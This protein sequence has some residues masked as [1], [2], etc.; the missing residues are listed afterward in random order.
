VVATGL[1]GPSGEP[2]REIL[3]M[4]A[5]PAQGTARFP[6]RLRLHRET[7]PGE[8]E[9]VMRLEN[10][11]ESRVL[12]RVDEQAALRVRP[13]TLE[14]AGHPGEWVVRTVTVENVGNV[15][16][17]LGKLGS[18]ILDEDAAF[19]RA[20]QLALRRRGDEGARQVADAFAAEFAGSRVDLLRARLVERALRIDVGEAVRTDIEFHLPVQLKPG[21]TYV[22]RLDAQQLRIGITVRAGGRGAASVIEATRE[23]PRQEGQP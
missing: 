17:E 22:G 15:P 2:I 23:T 7:P 11:Q 10:G 5:V 13:T 6:V 19:C 1:L 20:M 14:L 8:H 16:A 9:I 12:V 4:R 21:R 3:V 18:V